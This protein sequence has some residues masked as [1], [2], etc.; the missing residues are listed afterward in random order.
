MGPLS[1]QLFASLRSNISKVS[2]YLVQEGDK[3]IFYLA[4]STHPQAAVS[5]LW[6]TLA[7]EHTCL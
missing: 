4:I 3:D 7:S 6:K 2:F 1:G 5:L